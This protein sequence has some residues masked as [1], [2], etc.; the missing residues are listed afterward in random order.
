MEPESLLIT[1][2]TGMLGRELLRAA[3]ASG[4]TTVFL[5]MRRS[6]VDTSHTRAGRLL[7]EIGMPEARPLP[8]HSRSGITPSCSHANQRPVRPKPV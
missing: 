4:R 3:L 7:A 6:A 1:G 5:L 8:T 2:A